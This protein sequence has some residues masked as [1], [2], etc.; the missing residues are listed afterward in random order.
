MLA[1]GKIKFEISATSANDLIDNCIR[2]FK[3]IAEEKNI[4][5]Q[6]ISDVDLKLNCDVKRILQVLNNLVSNAIKFVPEKK[7]K[8]EICARRYNGSMLF[9][10][11][12][13]GIGI[14]KEKEQNLFRKFYQVDSSLRRK[15]GGAGLGL[16]ISKE[17]IEAHKGRIWVESEEGKG[18]AFYFSIPVEVKK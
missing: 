14:S 3:I 17:I 13:N 9:T 4:S 10:V 7:G 1:L 5:L 2:G 8:I 6:A 11:K 18:S 16:A 12:D 15:V